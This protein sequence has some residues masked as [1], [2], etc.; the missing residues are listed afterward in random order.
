MTASKKNV[1]QNTDVV[2]AYS[3]LVLHIYLSRY[4]DQ[5]GDSEGTISVFA[6]RAATCYYQS[7][8]PVKCSAQGH[9]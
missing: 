6:S 3:N 4:L 7:I 8:D 1:Q 9:K 5:E 2:A